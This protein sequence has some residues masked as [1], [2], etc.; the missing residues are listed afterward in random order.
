M[1]ADP[2]RIAGASAGKTG[3]PTEPAT[4]LCGAGSGRKGG[5]TADA[6]FDELHPT[7]PI[8]ITKPKP[9]T[10][11]RQFSDALSI[12]AHHIFYNVHVNKK[13]RKG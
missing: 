1:I 9:N 2:A 11:R 6:G 13:A 7:N 10:P 8:A 5:T 12:V 3:L 4:I